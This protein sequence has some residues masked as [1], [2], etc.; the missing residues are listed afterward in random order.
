MTHISDGFHR[1]IDYLRISVTDRCN[2]RCVYCMP[3]EGVKSLPHD[4]VLRYE[5]IATVARAAA[6]IGISKLRLTGGEPLVRLGLSDLVKMLSQ[7]EGIDDVALTTNGTLLKKYA[8][9]MKNAGL[10]RVNISLDSLKKDRYQKITRTG[11]LD[12]ALEGIAFA[13]EIGLNPVKINMVVIRGI[14]DDEVTDFA[15]LSV[16]KGWNVRFIEPMPFVDNTSFSFV[17]INEIIERLKVF[18][19]LEPYPSKNGNGPAR[20]FKIPGS[21]GTIGFISPMSECFCSS[22]NRLRLTVDGM[23]RPCLMSDRELDLRSV[24]RNGGALNDVKEC[25][26]QAIAAKPERHTLVEGQSQK[27]R[28]MCQLGG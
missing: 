12:D 11:R 21:T 8:S 14:N 1:H 4:D 2:L 26:L 9:E 7:I 28:A 6:A 23:L 10:K 3:A 19:D 18:G 24:L 22:C 5:E 25:L 15:R 20:Y 13:N 16:E 27:G 17:P